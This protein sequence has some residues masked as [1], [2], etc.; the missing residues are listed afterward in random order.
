MLRAA[1]DQIDPD[2][3]LTEQGLDSLMAIDLV[4]RIETVFEIAV[5]TSRVGVG[6][7]VRELAAMV[8]GLLAGDPAAPEPVPA[9]AA[10]PPAELPV[11]CLVR[12]RDGKSPPLFLIHPSGGRLAPYGQLVD[13]LADGTAILGLI[14]CHL[15]DGRPEFATLD[16]LAAAYAGRISEAWPQG[17][18]R[19][20]GF[21]FGGFAAWAIAAEPE[22]R[23]RTVASL[24]LID[25]DPA[26]RQAGADRLAGLGAMLGNVLDWARSEGPLPPGAADRP[27]EDASPALAARLVGLAPEAR[28][29]ALLGWLDRGGALRV[30]TLRAMVREALSLHLHHV[31]LVEAW[32]PRPVR[33]P[34]VLVSG[35]DAP[36]D[37]EI[38]RAPLPGLI[39]HER[40]MTAHLGLLTGA[41]AE[42]VAALLAQGGPDPDGAMPAP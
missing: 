6:L 40:I 13:R 42:R 38:R 3:P 1:P 9:R 12:L 4:M 37:P 21:S 2:R 14:S 33:C 36:D 41:A 7:S 31:G 25:A 35:A 28:P 26:W 34:A 39:R 32:S 24:G 20:A 10:A 22:A 5:P 8:G 16:S 17:P 29:E 23:G 19:L 18:V 11:E 27:E 30:P 15:V